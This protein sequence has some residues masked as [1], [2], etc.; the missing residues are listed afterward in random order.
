MKAIDLISRETLTSGAFGMKSHVSVFID[1]AGNGHGDTFSEVR[2]NGRFEAYRYNGMEY[3]HMQNLL[4]AIFLNKVNKRTNVFAKALYLRQQFK[5]DKVMKG[6]KLI[7]GGSKKAL[8]G[9]R[10]KERIPSY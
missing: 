10:E 7:I 5:K 4:E 6:R 9:E 8:A 2:H 1:E 3:G